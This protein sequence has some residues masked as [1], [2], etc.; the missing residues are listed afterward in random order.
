MAWSIE[1]RPKH[2]AVVTMNANKAN[3]QNP[4]FFEDL[5]RAFDQLEAEFND[6][7][8]VL[9]GTGRVFSAGLVFDH[10]FPLFARRLTR[11]VDAWFEAYRATNLRIFT[12]PRPTVAAIN[13]HAYA[14]GLITAL[15][16]DLRIAAAGDLQFALNEVPIGIPMPAVYCEIIKHAIGTSSA[17]EMTLFGQVYDLT[18]AQRMGVVN[19]IVPP[20]RLIEEAVAWARAVEPGC[21]PTYAFTKRALQAAAL[22]AIDDARRLD[23][24]LLA[25]RM[26]DPGSLRAHARRYRELKGRDPTW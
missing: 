3:A 13:G 4:T 9:T 20:E 5:H 8:V 26:T 22:R 18:A 19:R 1:R 21:H 11:E 16:C 25:S 24:D 15:D 2:V 10:H 12:Y 14:G 7:G 17:N 6:C 23:L